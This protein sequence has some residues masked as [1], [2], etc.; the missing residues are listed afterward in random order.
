MKFKRKQDYVIYGTYSKYKNIAA[1]YSIKNTATCKRYI[2]NTKSLDTRLSKHFSLLIRNKHP[3]SIMQKD[4]NKFGINS[5]EIKIISKTPSFEKELKMLRLMNRQTLYNTLVTK[6][7]FTSQR[8]GKGFIRTNEYKKR[9]SKAKHLFNI[10]QLDKNLN[11]LKIYNTYKDVLLENPDY[12]QSPLLAA[13]N[14]GKKSYRGYI[15]RYWYK[16]SKDTFDANIQLTR[17]TMKI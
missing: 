15:W 3:N 10:Y 2:G 16:D 6:D 4:F 8:T 7:E 14:G 17:N 9:L 13:C 12:K 1:I 5:F 11:I